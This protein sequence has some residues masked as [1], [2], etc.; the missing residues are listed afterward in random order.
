MPSTPVKPR[1]R[2]RH[3]LRHK[4]KQII[5]HVAIWGLL[6]LIPALIRVPPHQEIDFTNLPGGF[7]LAVNLSGIGLFYLNAYWLYPSL[8]NKRRWWLYLPVLAGI[9]G[10]FYL[11]KITFIREAYPAIPLDS[12]TCKYAFF[13]AVPFMLASI[14]YRV[15]LDNT[16]REK[17][18]KEIQASQL[19]TELRFLRSQV[20][21]HFLFNV[22]TNLVS[23]ARSGSA[24]LEPSLIRLAELM[25]YMLYESGEKKVS[26]A[27]E[28]RYL[29]SYIQL[30]EL[31]FGED[32]TIVTNFETDEAQERTTIEPMLLIP[33][34][35]NAFKHGTGWIEK[36]AIDI[37]IR[38]K[39]GMLELIVQNRF[40]EAEEN[41]D[42][43]SGIGL[44][45]VQ[46]RLDLLYP[47]KHML[48]QK[49]KGDTYFV[50]LTI[51]LT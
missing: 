13:S 50:H 8:M 43:H 18:L 40:N 35:E 32:V 7:F 48:V 15:V 14:I 47:R 30:Q 3:K 31:R 6:L 36:P 38:L 45:N 1:H 44:A 37:H 10:L 51:D 11:V 42:P 12:N 17:K 39:D 49:K 22:L 2:I 23:L 26:I 21:P 34:V 29:R 33:F 27:D 24:Q 16:R 46:A 5:P 28:L 9:L 4:V 41:K 19:T 25:R 20:S